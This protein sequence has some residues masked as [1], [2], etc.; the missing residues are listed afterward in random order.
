MVWLIIIGAGIVGMALPQSLTGSALSLSVYGSLLFVFFRFTAIGRRAGLITCLA[1]GLLYI[2]AC[3][4]LFIL[5]GGWMV[6]ADATLP[7]LDLLTSGGSIGFM[8][9]ANAHQPL[10]TLLIPVVLN[11]L[12]P[13]IVVGTLRAWAR[14]YF[15]A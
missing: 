2:P 7:W 11:L 5:S 12:G 15:K 9:E 10:E 1:A 6:P 8:P 3:F 14:G 4:A 13:I